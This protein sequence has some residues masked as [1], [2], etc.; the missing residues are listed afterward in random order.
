MGAVAGAHPAQPTQHLGDVGAE[1][2]AVVVAFVDHDVFE[3]AQ[4][5]AP[6]GMLRQQAGRE[7]IG[8]A[9]DV[10]GVGAYPLTLLARRVPV[11]GSGADAGER[12]RAHGSELVACQRLGWREIDRAGGGRRE[13][14]SENGQ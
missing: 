7:Q 9:Q 5:R 3:T 4:E 13:E 14:P 8:I 12:Q 1:D 11:V 2:A 10:V 6:P